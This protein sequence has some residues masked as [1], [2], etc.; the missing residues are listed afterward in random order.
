MQESLSYADVPGFCRSATLAE[1]KAAD[2]ALKCPNRP[3]FASPAHWAAFIAVGLAYP[4]PH[5]TP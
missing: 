2:Y 3:P 5:G 4:L 1:I